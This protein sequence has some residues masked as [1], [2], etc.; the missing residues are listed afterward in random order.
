MYKEMDGFWFFIKEKIEKIDIIKMLKDKY[1]NYKFDDYDIP[2]T[3]YYY[4]IYY[5]DLG[6]L[7][8]VNLIKDINTISFINHYDLCRYISQLTHSKVLTSFDKDDYFNKNFYLCLFDEEGN[9]FKVEENN[10]CE[11]YFLELG[12][13]QE[14]V[15]KSKIGTMYYEESKEKIDLQTMVNI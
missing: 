3:D 13:P 1:P 5:N 9:S 2:N 6:F 4:T 8:M 14:I 11:D 15:E 7:T 12:I 10:Y